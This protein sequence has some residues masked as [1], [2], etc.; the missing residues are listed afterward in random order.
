MSETQ[1]W[2]VQL[3]PQNA[4]QS[5]KQGLFGCCLVF[6]WMLNAHAA[7]DLNINTPTVAAVK[8]SMQNRH[9]QLLPYYELGV[10]GLTADGFVAVK[11][12]GL[13]PLSQRSALA[14]L[15]KDENIDRTQLYR[16]IAV[17][18]G[19]PEWQGEIQHT[20]AVRWIDKAQSNWFVQHNGQWVRK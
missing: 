11:E 15:V 13:V 5:L 7:A 12:A 3:F 17:A 2:P 6:L 18:N 8:V 20:F 10:V 19:H 14:A 4:H 9:V 16:G 1:P